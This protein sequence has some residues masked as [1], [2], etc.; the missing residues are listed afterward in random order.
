MALRNDGRSECVEILQAF[1][2]SGMTLDD[3]VVVLP[4]IPAHHV[5]GGI[6]GALD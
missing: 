2:E 6:T 3:P 4:T 1:A 5:S